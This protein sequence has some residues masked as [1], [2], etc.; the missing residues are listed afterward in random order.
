M[1]RARGARLCV[2]QLAVAA[3]LGAPVLSAR[4]AAQP[5]VANAATPHDMH[6]AWRMRDGGI[7]ALYRTEAGDSG[8][9]FVDFRNGASHRLYA[10]D[11]STFTSS[12][13]WTGA[14]PA[15]RRYAISRDA[16]GRAAGLTLTRAG[17]RAR[18]GRRV[19]IRE[20]SATFTS[21]GTT[22]VGKLIAPATGR[23]P[24]PAVIYVHGSDSVASVDRVWEPYLLAA[25]GVAM[26]VFDRR[27]TG[28]SGGR[29]TQ[30][31]TTLA[32]DVVA[33]AAWV[34]QQPH[35]D[36]TRIGLAGFSQ[37]GWVAPLAA[38]RD[39]G[40]R[41]MLVS[42]GMTMSVAEEDQLEAPLKLR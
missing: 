38:S 32:D 13:A 29:Y 19:A 34:R 37:G 21:G 12:D 39:R 6:G 40:I 2:R 14:T 31:F 1:V 27:G 3:L 36:S 4:T 42:Y 10:R 25:H 33:A 11:A 18:Y 7:V 23:G 16:S 22:L 24:W 28:R 17:S 26:F 41:F 20:D 15:T 35:I 5:P 8:W 30:L 9:R